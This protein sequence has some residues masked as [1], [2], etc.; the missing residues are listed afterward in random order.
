M[1]PGDDQ[2]PL[3]GARRYR[4]RPD[5][6]RQAGD[7]PCS[8]SDCPRVNP[9]QWQRL[10]NER[11]LKPCASFVVVVTSWFR[12]IPSA[13]ADQLLEVLDEGAVA[14]L[15]D[16]RQQGLPVAPLDLVEQQLVP[17]HV[18]VEVAVGPL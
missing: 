17:G 5:R 13:G 15:R 16:R 7:C 11:F 1:D 12:P 14:V 9:P 18:L 6:S 10:T 3:G 2:S 4:G 8:D